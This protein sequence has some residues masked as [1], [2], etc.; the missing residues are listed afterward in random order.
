MPMPNK[1]MIDTQRARSRL[2]RLRLAL[3][4]FHEILHELQ[5]IS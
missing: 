2:V 4:F 1:V 3:R 5:I